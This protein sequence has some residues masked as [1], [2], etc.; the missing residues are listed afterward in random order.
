MTVELL[1]KTGD[2][3][4]DRWAAEILAT[5]PPLT[6]SQRARL[7]QLVGGGRR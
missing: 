3:D 5:A 2:K 4:L 1:R 6:E 7:G